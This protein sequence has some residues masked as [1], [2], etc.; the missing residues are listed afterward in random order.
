MRPDIVAGA[1][2]PDYELSD[3]RG[4]HRT[5]A[6]LQG[7]DPLV[8]VLARGGFCPKDR[9]QH[10]GLLQLHREMQV[11]YSRLVTISTDNLLET[12][13]FRA[14]TG[15]HW[16]FLS[17]P[18]RKVQKDLDI[19]EYTDPDHNPMI[20]HTLVLEPGLRVYKIY[21]GYWFFGRPTAPLRE[22]VTTSCTW[23]SRAWP[24]TWPIRRSPDSRCCRKSSLRRLR[25]ARAPAR[26]FS[27]GWRYGRK[28]SIRR[29]DPMWPPRRSRHFANGSAPPALASR[30]DGGPF[31]LREREVS[32]APRASARKNGAP[33][34]GYR[35]PASCTSVV[36][37]CDSYRET[38]SHILHRRTR[39]FACGGQTPAV[40]RRPARPAIAAS[41]RY[42]LLRWPNS[43]RRRSGGSRGAGVSRLR[44]G[45]R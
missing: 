38:A 32:G 42:R 20:P 27:K 3:H 33:L 2:F 31:R 37:D 21:N 23:R 41:R 9:R 8:L 4:T 15:A 45:T 18:G 26:P 13:E 30:D 12:N 10:E 7:G 6:E 34:R 19:A 24:G 14:G 40:R 25:R 11:G 35:N 44:R 17:D 1:V 5:L 43:R 29:L 22:A 36:A 39:G 28:I 16:T